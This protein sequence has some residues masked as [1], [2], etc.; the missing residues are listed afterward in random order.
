[1][2]V[3][4]KATWAIFAALCVWVGLYPMIYFLVDREFGLLSSKSPALLANL[5][6]NMAFYPHIVLG[7]VALLIGWTQFSGRLRA[8]HIGLHR[9]LGKVYLISVLISGVCGV[10]IAQFATGGL[11]NVLAFSFSGLIWLGTSA[12]AYRAIRDRDILRHRNFMIYS[13]A[14]CF[15]AVT[16]RLWLPLLTMYFGDFDTAYQVVGWLSWVPNVIV[17]YFIIQRLQ[18]AIPSMG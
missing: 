14:V 2:K 11:V 12:M 17:A 16:L 7:G 8:K 9:S 6:W 13:Y 10:Y 1:M 5:L 15:S 3:V 4:R 18:P